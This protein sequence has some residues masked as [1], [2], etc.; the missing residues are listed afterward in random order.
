MSSPRKPNRQSMFTLLMAAFFVG[1]IVGGAFIYSYL[2]DYLT[3][4]PC[5]ESTCAAHDSKQV[6]Q[7]VREAED[8][9]FYAKLENA[10]VETVPAEEAPPTVPPMPKMAVKTPIEKAVAPLV[11]VP[12]QQPAPWYLQVASLGK[13]EEADA[14]KAKLSLSGVA[15][16]VV[17]IEL[18]EHGTRYRV[19]VGP[20]ASK[21]QALEARSKLTETYAG[22]AQA[23]LTR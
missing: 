6:A 15:V 10:P 23:I 16:E 11:V 20:Y 19:R 12:D 2:P 18:P 5:D 9:D 22:A 13:P 3:A 4:K 8:F 1:V 14:L 7:P 21:D 17:N